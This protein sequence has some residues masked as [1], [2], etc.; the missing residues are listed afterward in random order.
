MPTKES[1]S[2]SNNEVIKRNKRI[3]RPKV[4]DRLRLS[5]AHL[6]SH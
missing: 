5:W 2:Y 6:D 3:Q 1:H 4:A